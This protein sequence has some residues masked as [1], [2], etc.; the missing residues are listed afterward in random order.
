MPLPNRGARHYTTVLS[1]QIATRLRVASSFPPP[2]TI[3][4]LFSLCSYPSLLFAFPL[5]RHFL[6][7]VFIFGRTVSASLAF[8]TC[9]LRFLERH[10]HF[11]YACPRVSLGRSSMI[12]SPECPDAPRLCFGCLSYGNI[13]IPSGRFLCPSHQTSTSSP[14]GRWLLLGDEASA[15]LLIDCDSRYWG[16]SATYTRAGPDPH[17]A[18][19]RASKVRDLCNVV[20]CDERRRSDVES[21][22]GLMFQIAAGGRPHLALQRGN[23]LD[24]GA[25]RPSALREVVIPYQT[26]TYVLRWDRRIYAMRFGPRPAEADPTLQSWAS[27]EWA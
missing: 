8:V 10:L 19:R 22:A 6:S 18:M 5:H 13:G 16:S 14:A 27:G 15:P 23:R 21:H 25:S 17:L 7:S 12:S 3:F 4:I 9:H 24:Y 11:R 2:S 20:L 26:S 1:P